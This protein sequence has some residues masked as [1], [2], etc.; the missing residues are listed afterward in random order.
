MKSLLHRI[1]KH[2]QRQVWAVIVA[3]M[4]A[5]HNFYKNDDKLPDDIGDVIELNE[6]SEDAGPGGK[7]H[8]EVLKLPE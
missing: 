1:V 2:V 7:P 3:Y 8:D 4:V 5:L 6:I